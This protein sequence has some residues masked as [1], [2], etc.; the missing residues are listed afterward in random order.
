MLAERVEVDVGRDADDGLVHSRVLVEDE[1]VDQVVA[2]GARG[3]EERKPARE[4]GAEPRD[5]HGQPEVGLLASGAAPRAEL[6]GGA[7]AA[8]VWRSRGAATGASGRAA[9][10]AQARRD[11]IGFLRMARSAASPSRAALG[12]AATP[13]ADGRRL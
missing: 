5:D 8:A 12:R 4:G 7:H 10:R 13:A 3:D 1:P 6:R 11:R 2:A 9:R